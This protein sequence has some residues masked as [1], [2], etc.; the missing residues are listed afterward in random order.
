[1]TDILTFE[2]I[3]FFLFSLGFWPSVYIFAKKYN[4]SI[5]IIKNYIH[6]LHAI[7]FV[8]FYKNLDH[9]LLSYP[10]IFSLGFYSC[11]M[12]YIFYKIR[13]GDS[14]NKH[15]PYII[16][17]VIANYGL[18][19]ALTQYFRQEIMHFYYLLEYSNF[20][21][22][23]SY[24]IQKSYPNQ[25]IFIL[26]SECFQLVW[27][28]YF[29]IIRFLVYWFQIKNLYFD[30]YFLIQLC[31]IVLFYMGAYWSFKLFKKCLNGLHIVTIQ[32]KEPIDHKEYDNIK[33]D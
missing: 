28:S 21:L 33:L 20:L 10:I 11:D 6:F 1:M 32:S 14:C 15:L 17:H 3:F 12:V 8:V 5:V 31:V 23:I 29:R 25:T 18:Y 16:H 13:K 22:Y 19:L 9:S 27:Y 30:A 2:N 26:V 7:L 24:H 4:N